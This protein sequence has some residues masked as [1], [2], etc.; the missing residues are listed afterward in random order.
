MIIGICKPKTRY[1]VVKCPLAITIFRWA[2]RM[3]PPAERLFSAGVAALQ[4]HFYCLWR[5]LNTQAS[6]TTPALLRGGRFVAEIIAGN[7]GLAE[8]L[9]SVRWVNL[10]SMIHY[11]HHGEAVLAMTRLPEQS[12]ELLASSAALSP[13]LV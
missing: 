7:A 13:A 12:A 6:C 8:A 3:L 4:M 2:S 1:V 5:V 9:F 10:K 11:L